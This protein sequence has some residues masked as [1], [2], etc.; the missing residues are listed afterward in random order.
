MNNLQD[1]ITKLNTMLFLL[2]R[3]LKRV[4][5]KE[6]RITDISFYSAVED[7]CSYIKKII[8]NE[9]I[10]LL[11]NRGVFIDFG[12]RIISI[13]DDKDNYLIGRQFNLSVTDETGHTKL[14]E[15]IFSY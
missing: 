3:F 14:G 15:I 7:D 13:Y 10:P 4:E 8:S 1:K 11:E 6:N 2:G 12:K 5:I 9:V